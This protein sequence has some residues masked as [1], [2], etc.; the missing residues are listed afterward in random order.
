[1]I[2]ESEKSSKKPDSPEETPPQA[3]R[4]AKHA[5]GLSGAPCEAGTRKGPTD[6][7]QNGLDAKGVASS[8]VGEFVQRLLSNT[9]TLL[10]SNDHGGNSTLNSTHHMDQTS[11]S[12][13]ATVSCDRK[14]KSKRSVQSLRNQ[15][16]SALETIHERGDESCELE[17][18]D[19]SSLSCGPPT[20]SVRSDEETAREARERADLPSRPEV[21]AGSQEKVSIVPPAES[22][23]DSDDD[24][25]GLVYDSDGG[26]DD[27][28]YF[29]LVCDIDG[30]RV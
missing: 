25:P 12:I 5:C 29:E 7:A 24:M 27:Q 23:D 15:H 10:E 22:A 17:D 1:M 16:A 11:L 8:L 30:P 20:S 13:L 21:Q 19:R 4:L 3:R 18:A 28:I 14:P 6:G 26:D 9:F 2:P